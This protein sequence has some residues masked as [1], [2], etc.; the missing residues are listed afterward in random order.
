MTITAPTH[1][2][3]SASV[4][5]AAFATAITIGGVAAGPSVLS[6]DAYAGTQSPAA[7]S[8]APVS[9]QPAYHHFRPGFRH[10]RPEYRHHRPG[11]RH[12]RS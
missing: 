1:H 7:L 10:F 6:A 4:A 5:A 2:R 3:F 12:F 8:A 11:F 9:V